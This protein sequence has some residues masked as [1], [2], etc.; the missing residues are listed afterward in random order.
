M[1]HHFDLIGYVGMPYYV[2]HDSNPEHLIPNADTLSL[3]QKKV[4]N[5]RMDQNWEKRNM[6]SM[7]QHRLI[8]MTLLK[9]SEIVTVIKHNILTDHLNLNM[10][11]MPIYANIFTFKMQDPYSQ[12]FP[13]NIYITEFPH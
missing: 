7:S 2:K 8:L 5:S 9:C 11:L 12:N 3:S 4:T 13:I 1:L 10:F 6:V